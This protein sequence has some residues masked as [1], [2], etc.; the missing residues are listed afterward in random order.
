MLDAVPLWSLVSLGPVKTNPFR[1]SNQL[2]RIY[3][4][5]AINRCR[6]DTLASNQI[7]VGLACSP[8]THTTSLCRSSSYILILYVYVYFVCMCTRVHNMWKV[9]RARSFNLSWHP[10][11]LFEQYPRGR[12]RGGWLVNSTDVRGRLQYGYYII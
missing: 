12:R 5:A 4:A 10:N 9:T 11:I 7:E 1:R 8:V 3:T 2:I 6:P